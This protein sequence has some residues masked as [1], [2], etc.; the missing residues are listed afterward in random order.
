MKNNENYSSGDENYED[1]GDL[2]DAFERLEEDREIETH[3]ED[4]TALFDC[5]NSPYSQG[6]CKEALP[7][8]TPSTSIDYSQPAHH[9]EQASL[10]DAG[11]QTMP[12]HQKRERASHNNKLLLKYKSEHAR[13]N[14]E[15]ALLRE[16][17][18]KAKQ[19]I[20]MLK[21]KNR[22]LQ[23]NYEILAKDA[24]NLVNNLCFSSGFSEKNLLD[25][26]SSRKRGRSSTSFQQKR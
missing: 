11:T 14:Q 15:T 20:E 8:L 12:L 13:L 1:V 24:S 2:S 21:N 5:L 23:Y 25:T 7:P 16:K 6:N 3:E 17:L 22:T 26:N 18:L 19:E 9:I 10:F 4:N